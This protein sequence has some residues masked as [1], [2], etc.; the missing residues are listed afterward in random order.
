M[1]RPSVNRQTV[2]RWMDLW[3]TDRPSGAGRTSGQQT[4]PQVMDGPSVNRQTVRRW[5]DLRSTDRPSGAGR[6]SG[7]QT[8]RRLMAWWRTDDGRSKSTG[9]R[10]SQWQSLIQPVPPL[11]AHKDVERLRLHRL[12]VEQKSRAEWD[13]AKGNR[14]VYGRSRGKGGSPRLPPRRRAHERTIAA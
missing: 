10:G 8:D 1:D 7:Q 9:I 13:E 11:I 14:R 4:D 6:T 5:T 2:R 12:R 3:S